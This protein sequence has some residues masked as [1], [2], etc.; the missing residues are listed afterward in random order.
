[1]VD[2]TKDLSKRIE[3]V[4][5]G[6]KKLLEDNKLDLITTVDF[7]KYRQLPASVQ[8]ALTILE[9]EGGVVVRKYNDIPKNEK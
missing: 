2:E 6:L 7:P 8:L 3:A 4:E 1:M 9:Q 5:A